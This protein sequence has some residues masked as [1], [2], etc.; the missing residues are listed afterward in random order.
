MEPSTSG[1]AGPDIASPVALEVHRVAKIGGGHEL[2][3]A[4]GPGIGAQ[5]VRRRH[6]AVVE[7]VQGG[8]QLSTEEAGAPA[9]PGESGQR[10]DHME[11]AHPGAE[12]GLQ[13]PNAGDDA[14]IDPEPCAH[15]FQ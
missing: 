1:F 7:D 8:D 10:L 14:R 12:A 11:V 5:H 6:V 4:H 3:L 15:P 9:V 2:R 13:S